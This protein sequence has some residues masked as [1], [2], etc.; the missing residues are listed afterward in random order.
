MV[1]GAMRNR[2]ELLVGSASP[3]WPATW[4]RRARGS[5]KLAVV[6]VACSIQHDPASNP[7]LWNGIKP[8]PTA[9]KYV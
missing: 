7:M 1:A 2:N 3:G 5:P 6:K 4:R 9:I 8:L